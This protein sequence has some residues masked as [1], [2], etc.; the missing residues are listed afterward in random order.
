MLAQ[1][2]KDGDYRGYVQIDETVSWHLEDCDGS[3]GDGQW[4][5]VTRAV[6]VNQ[7]VGGTLLPDRCGA[8][9]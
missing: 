4:S 2:S 1:G 9:Q 8:Q 3:W 6:S 5:R 7:V